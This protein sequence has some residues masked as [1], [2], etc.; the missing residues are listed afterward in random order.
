[1][2]CRTSNPGAV[3]F[4]DIQD[5]EGMPLYQ[6]VARGVGGWGDDGSVG[7]VVGATYP[8]ELKK[9]RDICPSLPILIPGVGSQAGDLRQSVLNGTDASGRRAII[10]A[11]RSVIYAG[12]GPDYAQAARREAMRLRDA[13]NDILESEGLGWR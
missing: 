13:I 4:Q 6:R 7:L 11:S 10:N 9:V 1:M 5:K 12:S 8:G 2:L 3:D